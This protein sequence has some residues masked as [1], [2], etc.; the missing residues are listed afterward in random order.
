MEPA[1]SGAGWAGFAASLR[2][3]GGGGAGPQSAP[4]LGGGA[5]EGAPGGAGVGE[6]LSAAEEKARARQVLAAEARKSPVDRATGKVRCLSCGRA[7]A[8][9]RILEQ[10]LRD[11]HG[12]VNSEDSARL[13][14]W[15]KDKGAGRAGPPA[16]AKGKGRALNLADF[17]VRAP[18]IRVRTDA[19]RPAGRATS[20]AGS[21]SRKED[22]ARHAGSRGREVANPNMASDTTVLVRRG[23]EREAGKKEKK[24]SLMKRAV[25]R[26]R[27]ESTLS[28]ARELELRC[29]S[30]RDEAQRRHR[31]LQDLQSFAHS[32]PGRPDGAATPDT[33]PA[34][35][36][37]SVPCETEVDPT[38]SADIARVLELQLSAA[39]MHAEKQVQRS[40]EVLKEAAGEVL[41][42][43][44]QPVPAEPVVGPIEER[45]SRDDTEDGDQGDLDKEGQNALGSALLESAALGD[46]DVKQ[47]PTPEPGPAEVARPEE[48][49]RNGLLG[50][51]GAGEGSGAA[52][53]EAVRDA[54]HR[55]VYHCWLCKVDCDSMEHFENHCL[56]AKH[57]KASKV[58]A[59][60]E[61]VELKMT[62]DRDKRLYDSKQDLKRCFQG[63]E[64]D[65]PY[66][67]HEITPELNAAVAEMVGKLHEFQE[68]LRSRDPLKAKA[69]RRLLFGLRET[70]K[71]VN[72]GKVKTLI[73]APNIEQTSAASQGRGPDDTLQRILVAAEDKDVPVVFALTRNKMGKIVKARSRISSVAVLDCSGAEELHKKV[74]LLAEGL[75]RK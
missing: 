72:L 46:A 3:A 40:E 15:A 71:A 37:E 58:W 59:Q 52:L 62:G 38:Q 29:R 32:N 34:T 45:P 66:A 18:A 9:F 11:K 7:F 24:P 2:R 68:R 41:R 30:C 16:A 67:T 21:Q 60:V 73:V 36:A 4:G 51:D 8:G 74:L 64:S 14:A 31:D 13:L 55:G 75:K 22:A 42:L 35:P 19:G 17:A 33:V 61:L 65:S 69:R 1:D 6:P 5:P 10:H 43:E 56:G 50:T 23:K 54:L 25:L 47:A 44:A 27:E 70:A 63:P 49:R 53:R 20:S 48:S 57:Q 28:A 26:C 12:G 39:L